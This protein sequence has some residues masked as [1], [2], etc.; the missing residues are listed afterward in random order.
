M[1]LKSN[2]FELSAKVNKLIVNQSDD[3]WRFRNGQASSKPHQGFEMAK[4]FKM[5]SNTG[6]HLI[7]ITN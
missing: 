2:F 3:I 7:F 4:G 6:I 5:A 1:Q